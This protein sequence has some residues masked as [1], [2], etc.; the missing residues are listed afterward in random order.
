MVV[1]GANRHCVVKLNRHMAV[2]PSIKVV[3]KSVTHREIEQ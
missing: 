2:A 3:Y 1:T